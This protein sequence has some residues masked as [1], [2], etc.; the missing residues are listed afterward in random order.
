MAKAKKKATHKK[1]TSAKVQRETGKMHIKQAMSPAKIKVVGVG[2]G[3]GNAVSRMCEDFMRGVEFVAIN[4]DAQDLDCCLAKSKIHIGKSLTRGLGTGM[5]PDLG[6][7]AAEENRSEIA[8]ALEGSDI[9]FITAGLGGGT[10]TGAAPIVSEVAKQIG[11]LTIAVVTKPFAFEGSQRMRLAQEGLLKL[12]DKVDALIVVPN[13]RIFSVIEKDTSIL[14]A[15]QAI[16]DVLRNAVQGIVDVIVMPGMINLDFSDLRVIIQDAGMAIIGVGSGTGTERASIAVNQ[17][18]NSPLLE[19]SIDG[20][21]GVLFGI[22]GGR[23]MKMNEVNE[24]ARLIAEAADPSAKI[25]FGAYH[26][27]RLKDRELKVVLIATGFNGTRSPGSLFGAMPFDSI[28][29]KSN[30]AKENKEQ[31]NAKETSMV[32]TLTSAEMREEK[33]DAKDKKE[34]GDAWDIPTFLRKKR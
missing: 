10:G 21:K 11:A 6:K 24:V 4:T 18:I 15:F 30:G 13:D 8:A 17:A 32:A 33:N 31:K 25:I 29:P 5:N 2:G 34:K 14:K 20:A 27:R 23:D 28:L 1:K 26:D 3:G 16:D 19:A 7:Q 9:V 12:K 22:F